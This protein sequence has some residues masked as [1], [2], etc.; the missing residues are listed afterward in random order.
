MILGGTRTI[1]VQKAV[2]GANCDDVGY[3]ILAA[4]KLNCEGQTDCT[5]VLH[6][7]ELDV[8]RGA[9]CARA[10]ADADS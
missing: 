8:L 5:W 4:A 7:R 3:D 9:A 1:A 6:Y 10:T 2:W